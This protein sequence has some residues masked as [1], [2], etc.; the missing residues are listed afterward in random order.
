MFEVKI[1]EDDEFSIIIPQTHTITIGI[2]SIGVWST[3][4]SS[5]LPEF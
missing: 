4:I 3:E 1:R 5:L 2:A